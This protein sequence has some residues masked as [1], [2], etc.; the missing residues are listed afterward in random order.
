MKHEKIIRKDDGSRVKIVVSVST[1]IWRGSD[2]DYTI[3][4]EICE[5][6]KRTFKAVVDCNTYA[7]RGLSLEDR[8]QY[9]LEKNIEFAGKDAINQAM[10]E[11]WE[12]GKPELY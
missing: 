8:R 5:P 11:C 9:C 6:K 12:K 1:D 7:Y 3:S 10:V 2:V 4:V